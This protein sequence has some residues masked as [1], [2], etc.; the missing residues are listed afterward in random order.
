VLNKDPGKALDRAACR[1]AL[2]PCAPQL[3]GPAIPTNDALRLHYCRGFSK[4][5]TRL[6]DR[7]RL[8]HLKPCRVRLIQPSALAQLLSRLGG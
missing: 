2:V 1:P 8:N 7:L 3:P 5:N 4:A 6:G